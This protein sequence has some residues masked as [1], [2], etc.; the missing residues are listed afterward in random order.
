MCGIVGVIQK[1]NQVNKE[2][3]DRML[4]SIAHRGPEDQRVWFDAAEKVA[5]GHRRLAIIDLSEGGAL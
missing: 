2:V 4:Y 1:N 3:F 5:F